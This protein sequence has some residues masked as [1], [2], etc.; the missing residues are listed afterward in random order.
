MR[1]TGFTLIELLVVIAIIAILAAILFPVFAKAREKARQAACISNLKQ[2]GLATGMYET[3]YDGRFP[4]WHWEGDDTHDGVIW[5]YALQ[6][7]IRNWGLF[8]CPS[9]GDLFNSWWYPNSNSGTVYPVPP[10]GLSYGV[11]EVLH[12]GTKDGM[13]KDPATTYWASDAIAAIVCPWHYFP[14]RITHAHDS[15]KDAHNDQ[16][17]VLMA[18]LHVKSYAERAIV[19]AYLAG[20]FGMYEHTTPNDAPYNGGCDINNAY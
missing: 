18:D 13:V 3:D 20:Q 5:P 8:A 10:D 16:I 19:P 15:R 6:P 9:D 12:W 1:R 2:I 17:N 14:C 4:Y 11:S 7:Y